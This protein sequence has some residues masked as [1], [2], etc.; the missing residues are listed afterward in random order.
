MLKPVTQEVW[1]YERHLKMAGLLDLPRRTTVVR[2]SDGSLWVHNVNALDTAGVKDAIDA[3]GPVRHIVAPNK[4]HHFWVDRWKADYPDATVYA[5]RGLAKK[6]PDLPIDVT[7]GDTAPSEWDDAFDMLQT[8]GHPALREVVF[9][10]RTSR[11]LILTDWVFNVGPHEPAVTRLLF[12][13][14][15]CYCQL[16]PSRLFRRFAED[17][18]RIRDTV[19]TICDRWDF[20]RIVMAHGMVAEAGPPELRAAYAD[21]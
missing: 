14:N 21:F 5:A 8:E 11:T 1:E 18:A 7:L 10:H 13:I 17:K 4:F 2:L 16:R 20:Q 9:F 19:Q 12:R 6:K 15:G 3:L